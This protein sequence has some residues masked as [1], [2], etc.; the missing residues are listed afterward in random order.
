MKRVGRR[1]K[2]LLQEEKENKEILELKEEDRRNG[3]GSLTHDIRN[4]SKLCSK[5]SLTYQQAANL[6]IALIIIVLWL[7][8]PKGST[9]A[10]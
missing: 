2:E 6:I 7:T 1:R 4:K 8:V 9:L 5:S 3:N 10:N